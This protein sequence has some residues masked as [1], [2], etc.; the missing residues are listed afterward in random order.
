MQRFPLFALTAVFCLTTGCATTAHAQADNDARLGSVIFF[1][2]DGTSAATWAAAR[3]L[4]VGPDDDLHWDKLPAM[5]VYRGHMKD[6]LTATS[7]GGAT[8]HA[9]GVK[10]K[11]GAFGLS[12]GGAEGEPIVDER[13]RSLSVADQA[14]RA[15]LNVGLVQTGIALE[16]GTACFVTAVPR[17]SMFDEIADQLINSGAKVML[18]GGERYFLPEGVEGV[19]G[20]GARQDGRNLIDEAREKG[21]TVVRTREELLALPADTDKVLGL[22]ASGHTFNDQTEE[23]LRAAGRPNYWPDAPTVA[24][25]TEAAL[26]ILRH[27]DE[28]FLLVAEE[29]GTDNFGNNNNANAMLEAMRRADEAIAVCRAD[30]AAHPE[31]LLLTAADSDGGGMRMIGIQ[32]DTPAD[33]PDQLPARDYNGAPLDGVGGT[34]TA[35]FLAAPDRF[36]RRLPFAIAWASKHDV[37]GAVLVRGEGLHSDRIRGS[38]DNTQIAHLIRLTLFGSPMPE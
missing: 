6:R 36:G 9:Y 2:P 29:E 17:R 32:I 30:V 16:P 18:S 12:A 31:T 13:G 4:Y 11:A 7:N 1:H 26:R 38:M 14:M 27:D 28:R 5:A 8:V 33:I 19:H 20:P 21:Y 35:P 34:A 3:A 15:G 25:M 24:E 37:S 22:F 23:E 10:V